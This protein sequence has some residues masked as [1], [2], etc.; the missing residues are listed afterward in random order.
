MDN[1]QIIVT[2]CHTTCSECKKTVDILEI[3]PDY[4]SYD[5]NLKHHNFKHLVNSAKYRTVC[6]KSSYIEKL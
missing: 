1:D 5:L 4:M 3:N 6:C 2:R